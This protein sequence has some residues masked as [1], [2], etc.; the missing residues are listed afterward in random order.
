MHV[1]YGRRLEAIRALD[2]P[3]EEKRQ[4]GMGLWFEI[5]QHRR[6]LRS[7]GVRIASLEPNEM[8]TLRVSL[9]FRHKADGVLAIVG[10]VLGPQQRLFR[11]TVEQVITLNS[12]RAASLRLRGEE[13]DAKAVRYLLC[14]YV[15]FVRQ[16]GLHETLPSLILHPDEP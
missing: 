14:N 4:Q 13:E 12:E 5:E 3:E 8:N 15:A 6:N 10:V 7:G 9:G 1:N 16:L 11:L 2:I